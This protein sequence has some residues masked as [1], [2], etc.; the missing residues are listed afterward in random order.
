MVCTLGVWIQTIVGGVMLFGS[1]SRLLNYLLAG[2]NLI[3]Q[4]L[5][6]IASIGVY[7][8]YILGPLRVERVL[9]VV[10]QGETLLLLSLAGPRVVRLLILVNLNC[11][12]VLRSV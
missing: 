11:C 9:D 8:I 12:R 3:I 2:K 6:E 10:K 1:G 4:V 5:G 7:F